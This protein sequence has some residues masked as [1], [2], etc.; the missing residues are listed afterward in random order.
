MN[1]LFNADTLWLVSAIS[2]YFEVEVVS[3][4][5][6]GVV[7]LESVD[8]NADVLAGNEVSPQF[9]VD[10]ESR[11]VSCNLHGYTMT[12][13]EHYMMQGMCKQNNYNWNA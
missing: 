1:T 11:F 8:F 9:Y 3:H 2:R 13:D 4:T 7:I 5:E 6:N 10:Q 12:G